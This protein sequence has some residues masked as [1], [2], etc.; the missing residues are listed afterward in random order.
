MKNRLLG[1]F[2]ITL[3]F[4]ISVYGQTLQDK[5]NAFRQEVT[6]NYQGF[7]DSVNNKYAEFLLTA[8]DWYNGKAP[9]KIPKEENPIPPKPYKEQEDKGEEDTKPV[10][11]APV[12]VEPIEETPQPKPVEPIHEVPVPQENYFSFPYYGNTCKVRMPEDFSI[13]LS[14]VSPKTLSDSWKR[15]SENKELNNTIRDCLETRL[16]YNLCDW[17][18]LQMLDELTKN[19]CNDKNAA[20]L[21]MA[22][23]FCQSGYQMRLATDQDKLV[24]LFG[25][26]HSI[27]EKGYFNINGLN[28]YPYGETS[29][30]VKISNISFD[31]E[32][33]LS[34]YISSEQLLGN[35][36]SPIREFEF[37]SAPEVTILSQVPEKLIKFYND[38][39]ASSIGNNA[40]T[41]WAMY[42]ETP[43]SQKTKDMIYPKIK[44]AIKDK[45]ELEAANELLDWIQHGFIYEYD[46]KVWGHDRAFFSEE[47]L[48]YPYCDCEDRSI[49]FSRLIRDLLGLDVALVY[50]PG[51]LATAV[52]FN[53]NVDGDALYI[54]D[55]KYIMCDPTYIGAPV[56]IQMPDL[57]YDKIRTIILNLK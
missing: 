37:G 2:C 16:R 36:L 21:L 42:A 8:W 49:L 32:T 29:Q 5:Y 22:Y 10:V 4:S 18:Y 43:L 53:E 47:T 38:Y 11:V 46:D 6:E 7:R 51:H 9:V 57:D 15:L 3:S 14:D 45:T 24:M 41:R 20:T 27:Y 56:G 23:L 52:C 55:R 35:S 26:K 44:A 19:F 12:V 13:K 30:T 40:L 1:I 31:G 50:Y 33:P 28:F 17:A 34:L 48:Y 25:S 54:N 39:P